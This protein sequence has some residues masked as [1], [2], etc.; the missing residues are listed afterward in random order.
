MIAGVVTLYNPTEAI[1]QNIASYT[2]ALDVMYIADNTEK[3]DAHILELIRAESKFVYMDNG[4]NQGISYSLNRAV[5]CCERENIDWLLMMDQDSV[6]P[7]ETIDKM[8]A[9]ALHEATADVAI[10]AS[11]YKKNVGFEGTKE[12]SEVITSGSMLNV[13]ICKK[14]GGFLEELFIDEV[15]NEYCLRLMKEGYKIIR[16]NYATF[17]HHLGE[18][19][20]VHGVTTYNYSPLRYYYIIRNNLYVAKKYKDIFPDKYQLR[21]KSIKTWVKSVFYEPD[22]WIK[23]KYMYRGYRD[24]KRGKMGKFCE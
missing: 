6:L 2:K 15:D 10:V 14:V 16:L 5:E 19:K 11:N 3:K 20:I 4:G 21:K 22:T 23:L 1:I 13:P 7:C 17:E 24:Y 12:L 8:R 9:Y 18:Q